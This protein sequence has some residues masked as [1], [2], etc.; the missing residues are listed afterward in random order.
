[1]LEALALRAF[2]IECLFSA[3]MH[4]YLFPHMLDLMRYFFGDPAE[5]TATAI[6]DQALRPPVSAGPS[7]RPWRF[8]EGVEMLYHPSIAATATF[9]FVDPDMPNKDFLA[10]LSASS[11]VPLEENFW[12]FALYGTRGSLAIDRATRANLNGTPSLGP[13]AAEI[14]ALPPCSYAESF[15]L[16]VAAFAGAVVNNRPAPV[17][18]EDGLA[19]L[20]LDA[21]MVESI[22]TARPVPLTA[23]QN[24]PRIPRIRTD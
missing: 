21:A 1:M 13:L 24:G 17:T 22:R 2:G 20:R 19:A 8:G 23:R 3:H 18:G 12:S 7:G 16:S 10:T 15:S 5:V 6:D 11:F 4:S 14:A 9:R